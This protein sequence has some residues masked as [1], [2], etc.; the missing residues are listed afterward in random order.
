[1]S[2]SHHTSSARRVGAAA[3]FGF[4]VLL[5]LGLLVGIGDQQSSSAS[6][7]QQGRIF[8]GQRIAA[9]QSITVA[10][11]NNA[12]IS[13]TVEI[14][15]GDTVTWTRTS[16]LH[17]V[18]ADDGSFEQPLGSAWESFSHQ[19]NIPGEYLYFCSLHGG[20]DGIG[21]SGKV[22]VV[23]EARQTLYLPQLGR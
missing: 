9:G 3:L 18:T 21:M 23:G 8:A 14:K 6:T 12:F 16:G 4:A 22:I 15:A 20:P 17:S 1:M 7:Q 10:V 5:L 2:T 13:A 19:F 11:V